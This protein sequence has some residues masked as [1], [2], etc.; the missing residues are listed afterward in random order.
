MSDFDK[1]MND[2]LNE[3]DSEF[4]PRRE[5]NWEKLSERLADFESANPLPADVPKPVMRPVWRRWALTSAAA[6]LVGVSGLLMWHFNEVKNVEKE[7][8]RLQQEVAALKSNQQ[9][10]NSNTVVEQK[11]IIQTDTIYRTTKTLS[12]PTEFANSPNK[13]TKN[14]LPSANNVNSNTPSVSPL[15]FRQKQANT[16]GN[17]QNAAIVDNKLKNDKKETGKKESPNDVII[18]KRND[19]Q[20]SEMGNKKVIDAVPFDKKNQPINGQKAQLNEGIAHQ[21]DPSVSPS[22]LEANKANDKINKQNDVAISPKTGDD[23]IRIDRKNIDNIE[24]V[25]QTPPSVL[26]NVSDKKDSLESAKADVLAF[27]KAKED[28][29]TKARVALQEAKSNAENATP[30][31]V[32]TDKGLKR[33][34][35]FL[36][37]GFAV[38]AQGFYGSVMPSIPGVMATTGKGIS[39]EL[40]LTKNIR[41]AVS[42][43]WLETHFELRERPRRFHLPDAPDPNKPNVD[44]HRIKGEQKSRLLSVNAKYVFGD[45]WFVQPF[46][47]VGHSWLKIQEHSVDFVFRDFTTGND[48]P[49]PAKV[50]AETFKSLWQAGVG[51]EK[52]IWRFT[53]GVSAEMQKDLSNPTDPMGKSFASDFGILRGG[54]KFNIF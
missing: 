29:L 8:S 53:F 47:S 2:R 15:D 12:N 34:Q 46:V 3:D 36:P 17:K 52:K 16:D 54:V 18:Q 42:N 37:K 49:R 10:A 31:I 40:A 43:D 9:S 24:T 35:K 41:L 23:S 5:A 32:K 19:S 14:T 4:F 44:L 11:V 26:P 13:L 20:L 22:V 1:I 51:L 50:E 28:S 30:P 6:A 7:N 27:Q 48:T 21:I 45:K 25:V 33:L 38:G 39:A